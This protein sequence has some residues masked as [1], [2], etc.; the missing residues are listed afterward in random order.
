MA[1]SLRERL[2]EWRNFEECLFHDVRPILFGYGLDLVMNYVWDGGA[3]RE[4]VLDVPRLVTLRMLGVDY[5][6]FIGGLTESMKGDQ[7]GINWG[8]S[9]VA[10][11]VPISAPPGLGIAVEWEGSRRL[12]VRFS[13][14]EILASE[15]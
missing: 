10:Q 9:E 1:H 2:G 4:D 7:G 8:L 3:I 14:L 12:E 6:C 5:L 15:S 13:E 11:V